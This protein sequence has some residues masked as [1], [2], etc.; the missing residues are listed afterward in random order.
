MSK[1]TSVIGKIYLALIY[2][3]LYAPILVIGLFSFNVSANTYTLRCPR[4]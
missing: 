1:K 4:S 2:V 3:F